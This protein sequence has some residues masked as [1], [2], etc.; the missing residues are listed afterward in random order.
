MRRCIAIALVLLAVGTVA[1][2]Q[3][4][5]NTHSRTAATG[6]NGPR[7]LPVDLSLLAAGSPF[8]VMQQ[9]ERA[10]AEGGLRD[11]RLT[12]PSGRVV[13]YIFVYEPGDP[14]WRAG[15]ILPIASTKTSSGFEVDFT[16]SRSVDRVRIMGLPAPFL[17]RLRLEGSGDRERWTV[18]QN[19]GT[20]FDLPDERIANTDLAFVPGPYRYVRVTWNDT[21]SG[22]VPLPRTVFAR[23][24]GTVPPPLPSSEIPFERRPSE[25]GRSRYRLRLPGAPL[26][27]VALQLDVD[28]PYVHRR[29]AVTEARFA[30]ADA[31]PAPLGGSELVRV[32]RSGITAESLRIP[33]SAPS[34]PEIDLVVEDGDNSPLDLRRIRLVFAE[35]P[36]IYFESSAA[37]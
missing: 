23:D 24:T 37:S 17:K 11:L 25:P 18:L 22:R 36:W 8:R 29:A 2:R 6:G 34:E 19:E 15:R 21:N 14:A 20:V 10:I 28:N 30:G 27:A 12:D 33:I 31:A 5:R 16:V 4:P 13:P 7:R 35:L 9:G 1:A 26:P 32:L 3:E